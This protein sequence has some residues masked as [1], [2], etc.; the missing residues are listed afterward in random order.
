MQPSATFRDSYRALVAEFSTK[1]E[2][3]IPFTLKFSH[4]DFD[5]MLERLASC[6][7][8]VGIPAGFVPHST[9]WLVRDSTEV[10]GVS[11]LRHAL[12]PALRREGGNIGYGVRPSA[13]GF[14]FATELL[15]LT[16]QRAN[17][18]GLISALITCSKLNRASVQVILRNGGV[19]ESEE[20]LSDRGEIVQRYRVPTVGKSLLL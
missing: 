18:I 5:A 9:F 12:T 1:D 15:R 7:R 11:N 19:L 13:R 14:G 6:S 20:F 17:E 8:G 2:E 10:V 3:L 4:E 16:L